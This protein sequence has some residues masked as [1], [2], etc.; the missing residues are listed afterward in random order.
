M[1][2]SGQDDAFGLFR[3]QLLRSGAV[4]GGTAGLGFGGVG[5]ASGRTTGRAGAVATPSDSTY[6]LEQDGTPIPLATVGG[7]G[8]PVEEIY[9]A[10]DEATPTGFE[11]EGVSKLFLVEGTDE[12]ALGVVH[13]RG[14]TRGPTGGVVDGFEDG[15]LDEYD[16]KRG[17]SARVTSE[18]TYE[19]SHSLELTTPGGGGASKVL[20]T[21]GLDRYPAAGDVYRTRWY[22]SSS[23]S[24]GRNR[25]YF[26][27]QDD[28]NYYEVYVNYP[29]DDFELRKFEDGARTRLA[30]ANETPRKDTWVEWTIDWGADGTIT[31][32]YDD[33]QRSGS[34]TATDGTWTDGGVG[35]YQQVASGGV[36]AW[37]D[38]ARIASGGSS[39]GV[40]DGFEDGDVAE[41]REE[42]GNTGPAS[43]RAVDA[44]NVGVVAPDGSA[45]GQLEVDGTL[46]GWWTDLTDF[47]ATLDAGDRF[48]FHAYNGEQ[49][50]TVSLA[51]WRNVGDAATSGLTFRLKY[52][53]QELVWRDRADG[54]TYASTGQ[55]LDADTW[56]WVE[57]GIS[58]D[59]TTHT[60][61][62]YDERGGT[63]LN[64]LSTEY[65][66]GQRD[67]IE[68]RYG[69]YDLD[70]TAY[71]DGLELLESGATDGGGTAS[72]TFE[73][74]PDGANWLV[75]DDLTY[76]AAGSV[77][78]WNWGADEAAGGVFGG[79]LPGEGGVTIHPS[80]GEDS[81]IQEW[82]V[83]GA[84]S[85]SSTVFATDF[86]DGLGDAWQDAGNFE[87]EGG[88]L[89]ASG[90]GKTWREQP[91]ATG[92]FEV[93]DVRNTANYS[94]IRS[95]FVA[96]ETKYEGGKGYGLRWI[97]HRGDDDEDYW[98]GDVRLERLDP[99]ADNGRT[100]LAK[101]TEDHD[102]RVNTVRIERTRTDENDAGYEEYTFEWT[103]T[104]GDGTTSSG[105]YVEGFDET[106]YTESNYWVQRHGSGGGSQRVGGIG[107]ESSGARGWKTLS[108]DQP[109][110]IRRT[111]PGPGVDLDALIDDKRALID[112]VQGTADAVYDVGVENIPL[113]ELVD[114][115]FLRQLLLGDSRLDESARNFVDDV[116]TE[117]SLSGPELDQYGEA[118]AR[119]LATE[120]ITQQAAT[121][122]VANVD[123]VLPPT[124]GLEHVSPEIGTINDLF[125][126]T[127]VDDRSIVRQEI[128]AGMAAL[129]TVVVEI[130]TGGFGKLGAR[131]IDEA[132]EGIVDNAGPLGRNWQDALSVGDTLQ[133]LVQMLLPAVGNLDQNAQDFLVDEINQREEQ[134]RRMLDH[135]A[136]DPDSLADNGV[137]EPTRD[138]GF[139]Q[140]FVEPIEDLC[141][142]ARY[143][144][145][146]HGVLEERVGNALEMLDALQ[147]EAYDLPD[148]AS[149]FEFSDS[150][151]LNE[152]SDEFS[153]LVESATDH[154]D[155]YDFDFDPAE[156]PDVI[157]FDGWDFPER[158]VPDEAHTIDPA[159]PNEVFDSYERVIDD[160]EALLEESVI[161]LED[162]LDEYV[163]DL[164]SSIGDLDPQDE[165]KRKQFLQQVQQGLEVQAIGAY[166]SFDL[167][168]LA[169]KTV[170]AI[171]LWWDV[172]HLVASILATL[173][174]GVGGPIL[175]IVLEVV[176]IVLV[177]LS[178]IIDGL[179]VAAGEAYTLLLSAE[180]R[181]TTHALVHGDVGNI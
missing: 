126:F 51:Y 137:A 102:G 159:T 94:G 145:H 32:S 148:V 164:S 29:H 149:E 20:S 153:R 42:T 166:A 52:T 138:L 81:T 147:P 46:D 77:A 38:D 8:T 57:V 123:T 68:W 106:S 27:V 44:S 156:M 3:R 79:V 11:E 143:H 91:A 140:Q 132:V 75:E 157:R 150:G 55:S 100:T 154:V 89:V 60:A 109:V 158:L 130:A 45:V 67:G 127:P 169:V 93:R 80:F 1:T 15:D 85:G 173:S 112:D 96:Q 28:A 115:A 58:E 124:F 146:V 40:I 118:L 180:H 39:A 105:T 151:I 82:Q 99:A 4:L 162:V 16:Q 23:D 167:A 24:R 128:A 21:S 139:F 116:P 134:K 30:S 120:E 54:S 9:D 170:D 71:V 7:S 178:V 141:V 26:G 69:W 179:V 103:L 171:E 63:L 72:F 22:R 53:S 36:K 172:I 35:F 92:V 168:N 84:G 56:Y 17:G 122:P 90:G 61:Y 177:A 98:S 129:Q 135:L 78:N 41:Y 49:H 133:T 25:L 119:L 104:F 59:G 14:T 50:G 108:T 86:E 43:F 181:L 37:F 136:T 87:T 155:E 165:Q 76:D 110:T 48:G 107:V 114:D 97:Q 2:G 5:S 74:V 34:L 174:S 10:S 176:G 152:A 131:S 33:G 160:F 111:V 62:L 125:L 31:A 95:A 6:V 70:G 142:T 88:D 73:G 66:G 113:A 47:D 163:E 117:R 121:Y 175:W 19:G 13:D 18:R 161:G 101:L 83:L 64:T 144:T 12:P 65:P